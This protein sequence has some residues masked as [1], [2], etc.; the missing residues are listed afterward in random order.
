MSLRKATLAAVAALLVLGGAGAAAWYATSS[1]G[2]PATLPGGFSATSV[3]EQRTESTPTAPETE[4]PAPDT[5][6]T[7]TAPEPTATEPAPQP[8]EQ[9]KARKTEFPPARH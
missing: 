3:P 2:D 1:D 7:E 6:E 8:V 4:P 5:T 9:Q